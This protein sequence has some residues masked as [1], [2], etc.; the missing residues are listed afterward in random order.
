MSIKNRLDKLEQEQHAKDGKHQIVIRV[1]YE[2]DNTEPTEAQKESRIAEYKA[3]HPDWKEGDNIVLH[4][5][6][7]QFK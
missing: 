4:W 3:K 6:D 7:G 2:G 1:C 5:K